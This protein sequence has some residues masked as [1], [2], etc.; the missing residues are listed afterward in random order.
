[1]PDIP[2][3]ND[4][5]HLTTRMRDSG[6]RR[7][8][9]ITGES[10]W[11]YQHIQALAAR[12]T[13]D[14]LWVGD[15]TDEWSLHCTP[16]ALRSLLGREFQHA[17][18]DAR[19]GLDAA[20]LAA[21][22]GT[23]KA[24]SWLVL[25]TPDWQ[26]WPT[27]PDADSCRWSDTPEAIPT[28]H[29][30]TWLKSCVAD[31]P[32]T[33]VWRQNHPLSVNALP[34]YPQWHPIHQGPQQE[35]AELLT[36]LAAMESGVAV[37][38]AGR[39]RGKSA[40]A[41]MLVN[42]S[43]GCCLVSAPAKAA[44]DVLAQFAGE[45]FH[46]IAPDA[47]VENKPEGDFDWL[48][49]DEAAAI[50]APLL[51][52]MIAPFPRVLLTTTVQGYEG[53]G[54][55]FLL[56]FCAALPSCHAF[57]LNTPIRWAEN[58]PLEQLIDRIML[59]D[60]PCLDALPAGEIQFEVI[61]K[62]DWPVNARPLTDIYRLLSAAHYRTSPLDWRRLLD[63][64]GMHYLA[65]TIEQ[66]C[67]GALWLVEEGGLDPLLS[68]QVWAG[69]RRPRGNLVAQSLAAHGGSPLAATLRGLRVS[70]IAVHPGHQRQQLGSELIKQALLLAQGQYDYLSVSFGYTEALWRFWQRCGFKMVRVG[71]QREAS[72][73]CYTV[74]ALLPL[75]E[76]G[77]RL[78]DTEQQ[79]LFRD[80]R[81]Y[82]PLP[83]DITCD[84]RAPVEDSLNESDWLELAGFAFAHRPL[85]STRAPLR[86]LLL[87]C[88]YPSDLLRGQLESGYIPSELCQLFN[89]TGRKALLS[90]QRLETERALRQLDTVRCEAL[91]HW[92]QQV[93]PD[94]NI[95]G[96]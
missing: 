47:L 82:P 4:F 31:S 8:L 75:S 76:A 38:T 5:S 89:L 84:Y 93:R 16:G 59:F 33:V 64:P 68:Q 12:I 2:L 45:Q 80:W 61:D 20:A 9:V 87:V 90:A 85:D 52:Q 78:T 69:F 58:D 44:T 26:R 53:T 30:I 24:G 83:L 7:L 62:L 88:E 50:P 49:V 66:H 56:K 70:R 57:T 42:R 95:A 40:L 79:R 41:G 21:L 18:F 65:A 35:Q 25:L 77:L 27:L 48:I 51:Q 60:E 43:S 54:R 36:R 15:K 37:V 19:T 14:W 34:D 96:Q 55:G 86:R 72:S 6:I 92:I 71:T 63:A 22:A 73:G 1:M 17:V 28:P 32:D 46:F 23:L 94:V 29:F 67:A 91:Q 10:Q 3:L 13:G 11:C 81:W 74:M 39:G